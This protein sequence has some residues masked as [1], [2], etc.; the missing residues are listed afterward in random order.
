[1]LEM[2]LNEW[3]LSSLIKIQLRSKDL[4]NIVHS[5]IPMPLKAC[6]W[7]ILSGSACTKVA[8]DKDYYSNLVATAMA[9][10]LDVE[11]LEQNKQVLIRVLFLVRI[12]ISY[13]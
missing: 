2:R 9:D 4:Y 3:L 1:M 8:S 7:Q 10:W 6:L 11:N 13:H 12:F 5:G